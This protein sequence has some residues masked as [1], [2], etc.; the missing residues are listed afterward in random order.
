MT[1]S[2]APETLIG[3]LVVA[4][5]TVN[6]WPLEKA[7]ELRPTLERTQLFDIEEL[8]KLPHDEV[9]RR[10]KDAGY[11]K[12]DYVVGLLADR[13]LA[14]AATLSGHGFEEFRQLVDSDRDAERDRFLLG[15]KGVGPAVLETFKALRRIRSS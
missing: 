7:C 15:I 14:M 9:S 1:N 4:M 12:A 6:N 10:L 13:L 5:L 8:A 2:N 11:T 3:D